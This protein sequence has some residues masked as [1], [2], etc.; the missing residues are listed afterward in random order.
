MQS[1]IRRLKQAYKAASYE[2]RFM[3]YQQSEISRLKKNTQKIWDKLGHEKASSNGSQG[4]EMIENQSISEA[5]SVSLVI[6][7][8]GSLNIVFNRV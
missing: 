7:A 6:L 1:E 2:R 8:W 3:L 5:S 4:Q